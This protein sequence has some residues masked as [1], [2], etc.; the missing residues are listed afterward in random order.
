M[1]M[2]LSTVTSLKFSPGSGPTKDHPPPEGNRT[3]NS[4]FYFLKHATPAMA[5]PRCS[6]AAWGA[7]VTAPPLT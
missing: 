7:I 6:S 2:C 4:A 3:S 5:F 1:W